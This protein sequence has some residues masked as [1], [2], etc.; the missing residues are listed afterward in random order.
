MYVDTLCIQV[1]ITSFQ[2]CFELLWYLIFAFI[3]VLAECLQCY[4]GE[5]RQKLT[6][7]INLYSPKAYHK[8]DNS[9]RIIE[10]HRE[11]LLSLNSAFLLRLEPRIVFRFVTLVPVISSLKQTTFV[12]APF[13]CRA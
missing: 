13:F 4:C 3:E 6:F 5:I 2:S 1:W 12:L 9:I 10:Y 8:P 7:F 11:K